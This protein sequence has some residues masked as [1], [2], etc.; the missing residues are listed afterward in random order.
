VVVLHEELVVVDK[1]AVPK[2]R[3]RL[4]K[5]TATEQRSVTEQ[6]RKEQ[7]DQIDADGEPAEGRDGV[8]GTDEGIAR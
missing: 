3:V 6:V 7:I 4:D 5:D 2:E 8:R 1:A